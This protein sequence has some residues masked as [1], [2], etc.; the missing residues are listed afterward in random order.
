MTSQELEQVLNQPMSLPSIII[1][2]VCVSVMLYS[3]VR[4]V[5]GSAKSESAYGWIFPMVFFLVGAL[6]SPIFGYWL[7]NRFGW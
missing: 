7:N 6:G 3:I 4:M 2:I 5:E 1:A